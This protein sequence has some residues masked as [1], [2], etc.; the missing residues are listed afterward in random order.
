PEG[1]AYRVVPLPLPRRRLTL[2]ARRLAA[3]YANFYVGNGFVA[4]PLYDDEND[5]EAL[6]ILRP[7]FPGRQVIGLSATELV[8]GGGAFHCVTQQQPWGEPAAP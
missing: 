2:G 6:D 7:L 1:R 8:T 4:V 3:S 5:G